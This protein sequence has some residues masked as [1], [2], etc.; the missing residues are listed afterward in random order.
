MKHL[1]TLFM[2]LFG[3]LFGTFLF[4]QYVHARTITVNHGTKNLPMYLTIIQGDKVLW[5]SIVNKGD[6]SS[7]TYTLPDSMPV[8]VFAMWPQVRGIAAAVVVR[9]K[10]NVSAESTQVRAT[11]DDAIY[12]L[13]VKPINPD[14]SIATSGNISWMVYNRTNTHLWTGATDL[15][16]TRGEA[17][18]K[19]SAF[20][21]DYGILGAS[22]QI[23]NSEMISH[24]YRISNVSSNLSI[25][26][27]SGEFLHKDVVA[28][29]N[30]DPKVGLDLQLT[31]SFTLPNNRH[32]ASLYSFRISAQDAGGNTTQYTFQVPGKALKLDSGKTADRLRS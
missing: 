32:S 18:F 24:L 8:D 31:G 29:N 17:N 16:A 2:T 10:I 5:Y 14:N 11:F 7:R 4:S 27:S 15:S 28:N 20:S 30:N 6:G 22:A 9:E 3:T 12:N 25:T 26:N 13:A 21:S 1:I 19:V 23:K